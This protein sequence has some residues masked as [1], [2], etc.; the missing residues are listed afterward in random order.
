MT[1]K[2][3]QAETPNQQMRIAKVLFWFIVPPLILVANIAGFM[4]NFLQTL[5]V[6]IAIPGGYWLV[7]ST[8]MQMF[9][10]DKK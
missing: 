8:I 3:E 5:M 4:T 7:A 1:N 9:P 6:F 2:A 10:S